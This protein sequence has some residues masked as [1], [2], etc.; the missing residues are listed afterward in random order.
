MGK[1]VTFKV[2][3]RHKAAELKEQVNV[4]KEVDNETNL[5]EKEKISKP[6]KRKNKTLRGKK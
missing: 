4:E 6:K 1:S 3:A 2:G 5:L